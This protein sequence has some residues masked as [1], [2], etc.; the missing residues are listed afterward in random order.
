MNE[1]DQ[2]YYCLD[3]LSAI[4]PDNLYTISV[5]SSDEGFPNLVINLFQAGASWASYSL[6][7]SLQ[8][9]L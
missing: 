2:N 1:V 3:L 6:I 9:H 7:T 8:H 5:E 4:I